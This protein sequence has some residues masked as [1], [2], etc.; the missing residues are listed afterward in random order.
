MMR[1]DL[2]DLAIDW[3]KANDMQ[4]FTKTGPIH[5]PFA[6]FPSRFPKG[7]FEFARSIQILINKLLNNI[8]R[9]DL[10]LESLYPS[11][12]TDHFA[13]KLFDI[14]RTCR[15]RPNQQPLWLGIF[16]TD[17]MFSG[18]PQELKMVEMN[19]I[20]CGLVTLS[21]LCSQ[22]HQHLAE[23]TQVDMDLSFDKDSISV[24]NGIV[25]A[26]QIYDRPL[27]SFLIKIKG[28][29]DRPTERI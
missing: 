10:F 16:R 6:L 27:Y 21:T 13:V 25:K 17:Y 19:T 26:W 12:V 4:L 22:M 9:D 15:N 23:N 8:A 14:Y 20:S 3:C 24:V 7:P 29:D 1:N 28:Y 5:A 2:I 18:D 11:L